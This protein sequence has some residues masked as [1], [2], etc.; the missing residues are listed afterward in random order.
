MP[1]LADM[2]K[3][4]PGL[5]GLVLAVGMAAGISTALAAPAT[6]EQAL[7]VAFLYNFLKF[8]EWPEHVVTGE[9]TL[10]VTDSAT[11]GQE[12]DALSGRLA[13]NKNVRI[14]RIELGESPR[15]CQLL[16]IPRVEKPIRIR[17]WLKNTENTPILI[18]SNMGEF[19]D[20]G[21]MIVLIDDG[22]RLQFEVNLDQ[23]KRAGLKLSSQLLQIARTVRGK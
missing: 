17:E 4:V 2:V 23:V 13:Q 14:K 21:G 15:E 12:L 11:F 9:L 8:A 19:L 5:A 16:F 22:K 6:S 3:F 1:F 20:L 18:V 7:T 10:C